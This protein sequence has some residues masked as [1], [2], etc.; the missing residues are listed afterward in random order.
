MHH[1]NSFRSRKRLLRDINRYLQKNS[2]W[3]PYK[4]KTTRIKNPKFVVATQHQI[5]FS[6]YVHLNFE[7]LKKNNYRTSSLLV[8]KVDT[9]LV[10]PNNLEFKTLL[11]IK[12]TCK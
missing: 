9:S 3:V 1:P 5:K 12:I 11:S 4:L 7:L 8:I 6:I 10:K 2:I